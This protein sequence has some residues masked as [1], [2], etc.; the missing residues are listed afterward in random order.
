M[1]YK[2]DTV[3]LHVTNECSHKCPMC[4]ATCE[5]QIVREGNIKNLKLIL[6]TFKK[7]GVKEINLVGGNPAEYSH[8]EE[9]I[10]YGH[11]LGL[12][13]SVLSN[14]HD[15]KNSSLE[16]IV[17]YVSALEWTVHGPTAEIHDKFCKKP[18]AFEFSLHKMQ[19][20]D[21]MRGENQKLG[22]IMNLMP[23]NY[24]L[25]YDTICNLLERGLNIDYLLIQ[26]I[27]PFYNGKEFENNLTIEQV[28][29]GFRNIKSINEE[30]G[31]ES[32][33]CDAFPFCKIPKELHPYLA[34]CDWGYNIAACDMDGNLSR[35][36]MS[37][38]YTLG[39]VLKEDSLEI[40]NH[41]EILKRFRSKEYLPE[42]CQN[43]DTLEKCGGG[44]AM[45]C[46][47]ENLTCDVFVKKMK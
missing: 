4:Y 31:V 40:W 12:D 6:D 22:I 32:I 28:I 16:K 24:N 14:T 8:I 34:R 7:A 35:C 5:N 9:L 26:R 36:A 39:N 1:E 11:D 43:W 13:M 21:D 44:C 20:Y 18:D 23:H 29:E 37:S 47:N 3:A 25:F 46:G 10:K 33:I 41:S 27:A 38:K 30:L 15:Y 42:S 19:T 17:P 45:S 2:L